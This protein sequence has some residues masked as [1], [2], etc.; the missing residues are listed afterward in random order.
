MILGQ[1]FLI[2]LCMAG[3]AFFAGIETGVISLNRLRLRHLV[4]HKAPGAAVMEYFL[5]EPDH[6]LGTTLVGTNL[7]HVSASVLAAD[8]GL[9]LLGPPGAFLATVL[10]V[11]G[12]LIF[13]EYLPKAWFQSSPTL[14][15]LP[16]AWLLKACGQILLPVS[17]ALG[18]VMRLVIPARGCEENDAQPLV[19]R[20]ELLHLAGEGVQTGILSEPERRMIHSIFEL[21]D[22]TCGE[23]MVPRK[24]VVFVRTDTSA[25]DL[26]ALARAREFNRFPVFDEAKKAFV[27]I[28]HVFDVLADRDR[29]AKTAAA[30]MRPPQ[31]VS[32]ETPAD[33][34]LPR[35]RVTRQPLV[36]VVDDRYEC[37]G[38]VT[39]EDILEEVVGHL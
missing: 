13:C 3:A 21:R 8:L 9:R 12:M 33:H 31:F 23:L 35:M 37:A 19:T 29:A 27:G 7:C 2:L 15:V 39:V 11:L 18:L 5:R 26:I 28:V 16:F 22:T 1:L 25:E 17:R 14:R 20:E 10:V 30:Y 36:M 38:I 6:L 24:D 32:H 34:V 4:R